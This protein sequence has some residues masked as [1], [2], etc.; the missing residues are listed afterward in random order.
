M[1]KQTF[2]VNGLEL[3]QIELASLLFDEFIGWVDSNLLLVIAG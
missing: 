3:F 1:A 2:V